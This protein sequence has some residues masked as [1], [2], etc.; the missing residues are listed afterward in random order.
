M[1][2]A[3]QFHPDL[4]LGSWTGIHDGAQATDDNSITT[5]QKRQ[6][7]YQYVA[8]LSHVGSLL[9]SALFTRGEEYIFVNLTDKPGVYKGILRRRQS[10]SGVPSEREVIIKMVS[11]D[12]YEITDPLG[13]FYMIRVPDPTP[14]TLPASVVVPTPAPVKAK[15]KVDKKPCE[16]LLEN[17]TWLYTV[18]KNDAKAFLLSPPFDQ[19]EYSKPLTNLQ[20]GQFYTFRFKIVEV[21]SGGQYDRVL[22]ILNRHPGGSGWVL[23]FPPAS[24][25]MIKGYLILNGK[26]EYEKSFD[27]PQ[28][29]TGQYNHLR[30]SY[31]RDGNLFLQINGIDTGRYI[32]KNT[33]ALPITVRAY[34]LDVAVDK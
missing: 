5:W 13:A 20:L 26:Y 6:G 15:A 30:L 17:T 24:D 23:S 18:Q 3:S 2:K 4:I 1:P 19:G 10:G 25:Q 21:K 28:Y 14:D 11:A 16:G 34:A 32:T 31:C 27:I 9:A 22:E 29:Q 7:N 33:Q 12:R 8:V